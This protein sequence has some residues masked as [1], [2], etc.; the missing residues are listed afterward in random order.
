MLVTCIKE[1]WQLLGL[2]DLLFQ[3]LFSTPNPYGGFFGLGT[4]L[5]SHLQFRPREVLSGE[6][7][8]SPSLA[9]TLSMGC[10]DVSECGRSESE[11]LTEGPWCEGYGAN[12]CCGLDGRKAGCRLFCADRTN[13]LMGGTGGPGQVTGGRAP[14]KVTF[15]ALARTFV[16]PLP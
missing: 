8:P 16:N 11:F 4:W 2:P 7:P 13:Y 10:L 12:S 14:R 9:W 15:P 5:F 6:V 1:A 3:N